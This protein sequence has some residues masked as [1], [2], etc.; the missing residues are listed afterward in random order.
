VERS[1][2]AGSAASLWSF[3]ADGKWLAFSQ[4]D[5][6]TGS[7][8]WT[9]PVERTPG[10][11][12]LGQPLPLLRQAGQQMN[13]AISSDE[14]WV[15]YHSDESGRYEVYVMP[16]APH[17]PGQRGKWQVS[18]EG[19]S[20]PRWSRDRRELFYQG[21]DHRV[22]AAA[23]S[24]KGNSFVAE[25]PRVWAEKRLKDF[26]ISPSFDVAPD[27]KRVVGL[28]DA[29]DTKPETSLRVLLNVGDELRRRTAAGAAK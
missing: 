25:K 5:P 19:G 7:D 29:E 2:V 1:P 22:M 17:S 20:Q 13:P 15:A 3:A 12:R 10:D 28:F 26:G 6:K 14:R 18:N 21:S 4:N 9:V 11:L 24:V 16:F 8:L 27:G 23:Y